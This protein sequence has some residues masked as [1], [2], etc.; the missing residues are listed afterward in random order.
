MLIPLCPPSLLS[1]HHEF[2]RSSFLL[3]LV[4]FTIKGRK[5]CSA[6]SFRVHWDGW[7]SSCHGAEAAEWREGTDMRLY[8]HQ[9]QPSPHRCPHSPVD[10][11][12][13]SKTWSCWSSFHTDQSSSR[14]LTA[15]PVYTQIR[16]LLG[17]LPSFCFLSFLWCV[18]VCVLWLLET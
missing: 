14:A 5:I 9:L 4:T 7:N 3:V 1:Y 12:Q 2:L 13:A 15:G 18:C 11:G 16:I 17:S 6:L 10:W 8:L